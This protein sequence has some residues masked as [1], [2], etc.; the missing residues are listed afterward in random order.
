MCMLE[1]NFCGY[2]IA[3][4]NKS[5]NI[6][7]VF[8]CFFYL[9]SRLMD[10]KLVKS[11]L[12]LFLVAVS[13]QVVLAQ[14]VEATDS[15][16]FKYC[17]IRYAFNDDGKTLRVDRN[18]DAEIGG[19]VNIMRQIPINGKAYP[20]TKIGPMAFYGCRNLTCVTIPDNV[21]E[22]DSCAFRWCVNLSNVG[23]SSRVKIIQDD[24]FRN[25]TNLRNFHFPNSLVVIHK[26]AFKGSGLMSA[27]LP[28][29]LLDI[30]ESAFED[31]R[32]LDTVSFPKTVRKIGKYAFK[33]CWKIRT[34]S[35]YDKVRSVEEGAFYACK[36]LKTVIF[37]KVYDSSIKTMVGKETFGKCPVLQRVFCNTSRTGKVKDVV[38]HEETFSGCAKFNEDKV[39]YGGDPAADT[40]SEKRKKKKGESEF[41]DEDFVMDQDNIE[42]LRTS[43]TVEGAREQI[44]VRKK[45]K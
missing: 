19:Q 45:K 7:F 26:G 17:G 30:G 23:I 32:A 1:Q 15:S 6:S 40:A 14:S 9:C 8:H 36:N 31:C 27:I 10:M 3:Y 13:C 11:I 21:T 20:V 5:P 34:V 29:G 12:I 28:D 44:G 37:T 35:L 24:C 42:R 2:I 43:K 4:F 22:I 16:H 41:E 38:F 25:C 39:E 18:Y 33:N